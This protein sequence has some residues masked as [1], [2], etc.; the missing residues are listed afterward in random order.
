MA[1]EW[2]N[3]TGHGVAQA[4]ALT[5]R[6]STAIL[7]SQLPCG[8]AEPRPGGSGRLP[9]TPAVAAPRTTT[10]SIYPLPL[11]VSPAAAPFLLFF[12]LL[13]FLELDLPLPL[14]DRSPSPIRHP[15]RNKTRLGGS[16]APVR[17]CIA[18][19]RR[20]FGRRLLRCAALRCPALPCIDECR[21]LQ[22]SLI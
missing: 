17:S 19:L 13:L 20:R 4:A 5:K 8:G 3:G 9:P 14:V 10:A 22:H 11:A 2:P 18:E 21:R 7:A 16:W 1:Q 6:R 12:F 15:L